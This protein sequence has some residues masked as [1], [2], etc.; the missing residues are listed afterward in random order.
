MV[1][2]NTVDLTSIFKQGETREEQFKKDA[3]IWVHTLFDRGNPGPGTEAE[4]L[5][6]QQGILQRHF[7]A[8]AVLGIFAS[9]RNKQPQ[10]DEIPLAAFASHGGRFAYEA[11]D[12]EC[13]KQFNNWL[14]HGDKDREFNYQKKLSEDI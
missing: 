3:Q 9:D 7:L 4:R 6:E 5:K 14:F 13:G 10:V 12:A 11:D 1:Q 8:M 2:T